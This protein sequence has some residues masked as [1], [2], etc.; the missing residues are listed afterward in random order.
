MLS[1][2]LILLLPLIWL[3]VMALVM[4]ACRVA[5]LADGRTPAYSDPEFAV[6]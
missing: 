5:A 3:A 4:T 1:P 6:G 2:M